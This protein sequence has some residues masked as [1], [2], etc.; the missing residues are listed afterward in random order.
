MQA[1]RRSPCRL[2]I[3][4]KPALGQRTAQFSAWIRRLAIRPGDPPTVRGQGALE[5]AIPRRAVQHLHP[6]FAQTT[7]NLTSALFG[8]STSML[9]RSLGSGGLN[10]GFAPIY[11]IGGPRS[12]QLAMKL[13]F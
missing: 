3:G 9:G 11:Q 6:N 8:I 4:L 13:L 10:G 1:S 12:V 2:K 5:T 7:N